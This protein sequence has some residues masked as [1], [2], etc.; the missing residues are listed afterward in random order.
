MEQKPF[1]VAARQF[2]GLREG[3]TLIGFAKELK[4]L[5]AEDKAELAPLLGKELGCEVVL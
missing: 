2:F 5:T 4:D 1:A 3:Q